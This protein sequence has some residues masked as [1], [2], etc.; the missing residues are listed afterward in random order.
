MFLVGGEALGA[1]RVEEEL[2]WDNVWGYCWGDVAKPLGMDGR[3]ELKSRTDR[4]L[5][6]LRNINNTQY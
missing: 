1:G 2:W 5:P 3:R 4:D 6:G